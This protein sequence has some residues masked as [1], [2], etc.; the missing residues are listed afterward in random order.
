MGKL[1]TLDIL[2]SIKG[3]EASEA[4]DNL[5]EIIKKATPSANSAQALMQTEITLDGLRD[6]EVMN[7]S[8]EERNFI[9]NNFP[10]NKNGYLVVPKV[11]ED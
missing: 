5:F 8:Q 11:I 2:S 6:D 10:K 1:M 9:I 3:A 4:V 7:V